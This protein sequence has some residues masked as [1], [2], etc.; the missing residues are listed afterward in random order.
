MVAVF[1]RMM[2]KKQKKR[3]K[4]R[5]TKSSGTVYSSNNGTTVTNYGTK[6]DL[7]FY[8][9]QGNSVYSESRNS[10]ELV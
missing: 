5:K 10:F 3:R 7:S 4:K 2:E 9:D 8:N 1:L 6:I